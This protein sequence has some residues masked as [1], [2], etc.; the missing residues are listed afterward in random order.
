MGKHVYMKI[1]IESSPYILFFLKKERNSV[2]TQRFKVAFVCWSA[3][4]P[5]DG[6]TMSICQNL[7]VEL[8]LKLNEPQLRF[9]EIIYQKS[10]LKKQKNMLGC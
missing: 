2:R 6:W 10:V 5:F 8:A 3:W 7:E 4:F 9:I 1:G